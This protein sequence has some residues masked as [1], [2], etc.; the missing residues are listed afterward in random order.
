MI[1]KEAGR[2]WDDP[3]NGAM[4]HLLHAL[5]IGWAAFQEELELHAASRDR[6]AR[7]R[8]RIRAM[9]DDELLRCSIQWGGAVCYP[10][11]RRRGL[12]VPGEVTSA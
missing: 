4:R 3:R 8:A 9:S 5:R 2:V 1:V 6:A 10:E 11:L 12:P 7:Q